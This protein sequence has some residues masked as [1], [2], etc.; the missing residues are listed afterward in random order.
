MVKPIDGTT[1]RD[2]KVDQ[3]RESLASTVTMVHQLGIEQDEAIS[4]FRSLLD[5][6]A[7]DETEPEETP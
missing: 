5:E 3:L 1:M 4:L 7:S 2:R 6:V